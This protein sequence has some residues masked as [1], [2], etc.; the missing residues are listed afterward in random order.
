MRVL[1]KTRPSP[2]KLQL[3]DWKAELQI[4]EWPYGLAMIAYGIMDEWF[5]K[6]IEME[7]N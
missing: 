6:K 5:I 7:I 2:L 4:N 3:N 1:R